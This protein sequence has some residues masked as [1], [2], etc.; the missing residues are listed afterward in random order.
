MSLG[1]RYLSG[2]FAFVLMALC[3]FPA[4]AIAAD[5]RAQFNGTVSEIFVN[6]TQILLAVSGSVN[7]SC[8]GAFGPYNLTFDMADPAADLKFKIVEDAFLN[9]KRISGIV[10]DCGSSNINK[11]YQVSVF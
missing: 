7:G 5:P 11:L 2:L 6:D 1:L 4:V 10:K 9:G 8:T 3:L